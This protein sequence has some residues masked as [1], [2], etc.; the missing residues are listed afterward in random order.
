VSVEPVEIRNLKAGWDAY[1]P[2]VRAEAA[3]VHREVLDA[4]GDGFSAIAG[5]LKAWLQGSPPQREG[6]G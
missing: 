6:G 3:W 2:L 4:G 5:A 1:S